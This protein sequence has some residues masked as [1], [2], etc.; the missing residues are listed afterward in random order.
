MMTKAQSLPFNPLF[1]ETMVNSVFIYMNEDSLAQLYTDVE[2]NHEY[3]VLFIYEHGLLRDTLT[4][5]G[6]RLRG[7]TSRY[8]AKK[9]FK[10]SFNTFESGRKYEGHEKLNLNGSHNDPSMIREKLFYDAWNQFGLPARRSSF[11]RVYINDAYYGL[12]TNLEE[13]DE[14]WCKER[15]GDDSGNRYKCTYPVNLTYMGPDQNSYKYMAGTVTAGRAYD[16][17]NNQEG[18]DYTDL[19]NFITIV[20]QASTSDLPCKLEKVFDV[21]AFLRAYAIDVASGNWDDYAFNQNNFYLY[22]NPFTDQIEFIAYD[23]DNTFGVDWFGIDWTT[24]TVY[25][26]Q[27]A[28]NRP[29][30]SRLLEVPEYKNRYSY[31]LNLLLNTV[32]DPAHINP[33]IDSLKNLITVA[34]LEDEY[35]GYDYG[36][37]NN[38]FL[39]SFNTNN[40]DG[41]TPYGVSNFIAARKTAAQSEIVLGN[42]AP[43]LRDVHHFPL[44]PEAGEDILITATV[45]DDVQM[46]TVKIYYSSDSIN[47]MEATLY[48]DGLHNDGAAGDATYGV[49]LP[50]VAANGNLY[51]H[52]SATDNTGQLASLPQCGDFRLKIGFEPPLIFINEFLA[53][54]STVIGDNAGEFDDYVELYNAG[55]VPV[56]LGNKY[57][58]DNFLNPSKW[59]LPA[60]TL[61]GN[62]YLLIWADN[63]PQQGYDHANFSLNAGGEQ[64]GLFASA[65]ENFAAIDTYSFGMQVQDVS[66]GRLPNGTGPFVV[67]PG[68]TPGFN[69][70]AVGI[71]SEN[72]DANSLQLL[73]NPSN[74]FCAIQLGLAMAAPELKL[75]LL[76][77][78]GWPIKTIYDASLP[79]GIHHFVLNTG[80]LLPGIYLVSAQCNEQMM[81]KKLVVQH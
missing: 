81:V 14:N 43:V 56:Y 21:D 22:H 35:K 65:A 50:A 42:I 69:N 37:T 64:I 9:S 29:L 34:A 40:I 46:G 45:F 77:L 25:N 8:S 68:P 23:C 4:N 24:R 52:L 6:F 78:Q 58:S 59:R 79:A 76:T 75:Q 27:A 66:V 49:Q 60:L 71:A 41:H 57:L 53:S 62:A 26:W 7:N 70:Y 10:V 80:A 17:Q 74:N 61:N 63:E 39:N 33:H 1:D 31:Y 11:V 18:D 19:V 51:F 36:Y 32:L 16:L 67:L 12:Y 20:N 13:M 73:A 38:D 5:T 72:A 47:F 28:T 44:L 55:S 3:S 48:D 15:F 54:N 2:S 30:V